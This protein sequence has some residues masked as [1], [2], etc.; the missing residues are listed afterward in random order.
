MR[1]DLFTF[2]KQSIYE[3][4]RGRIVTLSREDRDRSLRED[5]KDWWVGGIGTFIREII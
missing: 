1:R 3:A 4:V 2:T 5:N